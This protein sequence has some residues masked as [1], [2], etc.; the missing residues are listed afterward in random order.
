MP[1][2]RVLEPEEPR[3]ANALLLLALQRI[4]AIRARPRDRRRS[5]P[6]SPFNFLG[7]TEPLYFQG[8]L[9]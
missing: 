1:E 5:V 8:F 2:E 7:V 6:P 3:E 9:I 4:L